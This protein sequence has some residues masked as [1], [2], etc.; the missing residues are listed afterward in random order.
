MPFKW[1]YGRQGGGFVRLSEVEASELLYALKEQHGIEFPD[2][3]NTL[4]DIFKLEAVAVLLKHMSLEE[5]ETFKGKRGLGIE[6]D[7]Y[8]DECPA[9]EVIKKYTKEG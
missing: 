5:L 2:M 4:N 6:R 3:P 8:F 7:M 9:S 1:T